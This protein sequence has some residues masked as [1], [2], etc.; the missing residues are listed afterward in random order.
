L[1]R[2]SVLEPLPQRRG[3]LDRL[4]LQQALRMADS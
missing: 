2:E 4:R 1:Q 3:R